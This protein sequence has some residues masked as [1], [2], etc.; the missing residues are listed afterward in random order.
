LII[1]RPQ[2]EK[3][4]Q[5]QQP[6]TYKTALHIFE[7][8]QQQQQQQPATSMTTTPWERIKDDA[9]RAWLL[10]RQIT[11]E[12]Y[13]NTSIVSVVDRSALRTQFDDTLLQQ[14]QQQYGKLR[15]QLFLYSCIQR[16]LRIRKWFHIF[17]EYFLYSVFMFVALNAQY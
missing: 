6:E 11:A 9:Y 16:L 2:G 12:E 10:E 15:Y 7:P 14:Q 17:V 3:Q 13:N 4:Q 8:Q 5:Q 1:E